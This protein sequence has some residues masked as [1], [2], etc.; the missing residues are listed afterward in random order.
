MEILHF[1]ASVKPLK[2]H[3]DKGRGIT[4]MSASQWPLFSDL[5]RFISPLALTRSLNFEFV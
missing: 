4:H 2:L 1:Q 5:M 3:I